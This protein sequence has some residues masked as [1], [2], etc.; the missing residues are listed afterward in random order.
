MN[1][2]IKNYQYMTT[3]T[4]IIMVGVIIVFLVLFKIGRD[5]YQMNQKRYKDKLDEQNQDGPM[6]PDYFDIVGHN[7]CRNVHKLGKCGHNHDID[8]NDDTFDDKRTGNIM[9][10]RY[11]KACDLSWEK[12]DKM[13]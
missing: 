2:R 12:I 5:I 10:C 6:C 9:K 1:N 13:C 7:K 3:D 11:A 8:F 4:F